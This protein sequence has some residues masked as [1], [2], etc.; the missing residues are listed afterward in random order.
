VNGI[1]PVQM[2]TSQLGA[3]Q[4]Q[5]ISRQSGTTGATAASQ[6]QASGSVGTTTGHRHHHRPHAM[7]SAIDTASQMLGTSTSDILAALKSGQ[8]LAQI[9]SSKGVSQ[10]ALASAIANSLE[11]SDPTL[12]ASDATGVANRLVTATP[13]TSQS[14]SGTWG[15]RT[16]QSG[17]ST[18]SVGA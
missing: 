7:A 3:I 13:Q 9:A 11:Q 2:D 8:S 15:V 1:S 5:V 17:A 16:S 10:D 4:L 6:A 12:A 14:Q 18:M